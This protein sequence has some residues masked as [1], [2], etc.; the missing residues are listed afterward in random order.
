MRNIHSIFD[1]IPLLPIAIR[2]AMI[3]QISM[4]G[5]VLS[6]TLVS[7]YP[8]GPAIPD[9]REV[10]QLQRLHSRCCKKK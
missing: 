5:M 10:T 2:E 3:S 4:N 6:L 1:R 9:Y 8:N 7:L